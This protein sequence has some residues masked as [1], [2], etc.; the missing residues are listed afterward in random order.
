MQEVFIPNRQTFN[1]LILYFIIKVT[2]NIVYDVQTSK[3][4]IAIKEM[5][6]NTFLKQNFFHKLDKWQFVF[7]LHWLI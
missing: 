7:R 1:I 6:L 2:N 5:K 3:I 4:T